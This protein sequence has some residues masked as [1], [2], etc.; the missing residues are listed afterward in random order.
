MALLQKI[1]SSFTTQLALWVSVFVTLITGVVVFLLIRFSKQVVIDEKTE[2]IQYALSNLSQRISNSILQGRI[3]ARLDQTSFDVDKTYVERLITENHYT[4]TISQTLPHAIL[5][6]SDQTYDIQASRMPRREGNNYIF[7]EPISLIQHSMSPDSTSLSNTSQLGLVISSPATDIFGNYF[8]EY[9]I[10]LLTV[11]VG[12][13]LLL[14]VCWKVIG[15][16]LRPLHQLANT[17]QHIA[18]GHHNTIITKSRYHD[19]I[20]QLQNSL[21]TMQHSLS[22]YMKEME[23]KHSELSQ[24]NAELQEAHKEAQEY[25]RLKA[26]F[27]LLMTGEMATSVNTICHHTDT[28]HGDWQKLSTQQMASMQADI[29]NATENIT[30]LLDNLLDVPSQKRTINLRT[31]HQSS[32]PS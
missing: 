1:R 22:L 30:H 24:H 13:L 25:E 23:Q 6:V 15:W 5:Y 14:A 28:I 16:Y 32:Q 3:I 19:E 10:M 11:I 12:I 20:G 2:S 21:A 27:L 31:T 7:Y 26:K 18:D 8:S 29:L 9:I 17:A 4:V